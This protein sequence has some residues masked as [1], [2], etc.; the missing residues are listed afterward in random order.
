MGIPSHPVPFVLAARVL[1]VPVPVMGGVN[2]FFFIVFFSC[3]LH[4][5]S[6][7]RR[8]CLTLGP[9]THSSPNLLARTTVCRLISVFAVEKSSS[10][11]GVL[12]G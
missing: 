7:R 2:V 3:R 4:L 6:K 1:E 5:A 8:S 10:S 11:V 9:R 12:H